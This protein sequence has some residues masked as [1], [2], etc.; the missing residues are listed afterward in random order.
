MNDFPYDATYDPAVPVCALSLSVRSTG[1][2]VELNAI[3]DTGADGTI[4]PVYYLREIGARRAF[5]VGMRSQWGERR[6]VF[7]Y[8]VDM[9][10]GGAA[11]PGIYVVG[12]ESGQES[13]VGRNVLNQLKVLLDGP[14]A[15]T[16]LLK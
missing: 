5:E 13:V 4:I 11:L 8:L 3:I 14:S 10:I 1:R 6:E 15:L 9:Q 2:R 16:Q 7:L 12:D